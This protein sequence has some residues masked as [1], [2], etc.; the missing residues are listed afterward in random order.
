MKRLAV[1]GVLILT[2]TGVG[3][4]LSRGANEPSAYDLERAEMDLELARTM[5]P[6]K[7]TFRVLIGGIF[8]ITLAGV[9]WGA[10]R[11]MNHR[12]D[13]IYPDRAG[14]YPI[15]EGQIAGSKV[16]HDPNRAPTGSTIYAAGVPQVEVRHP[17]P[18]GHAHAQHQVTSQ[19][20]AAQALRAAASGATPLPTG[21]QFPLSLMADR[22]VAR[23]LPEVEELDLEP[24]HIERLLLEDGDRDG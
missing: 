15:R 19:A 13:T 9:G 10:I 12:A 6:F 23:P 1:L 20:Q 21:T 5:F 16:F 3:L 11:W 14:L 7:V 4:W 22:R 24:S 8:L 2:V 18:Q 17:L